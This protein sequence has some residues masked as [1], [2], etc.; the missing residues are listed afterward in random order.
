VVHGISNHGVNA[1]LLDAARTA[2]GFGA[3]QAAVFEAMEEVGYDVAFVKVMPP[4]CGFASRGFEQP[5]LDRM[6][7]RW[8]HYRR[9]LLPLSLASQREGLVTDNDVLGPGRQRLAYYR[10]IVQ[11]QRGTS[12]LLA[13]LSIGNRTVGALLLGRTGGLFKAADLSRVRQWLTPLS[14]GAAAMAWHASP[15]QDRR[16]AEVSPREGEVLRLV[17]LGYT[18]PEIAR[19]LGT[20]PN[21]VRNQVSSLLQKLDASTRAELVGL[22][23]RPP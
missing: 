9:E 16:I 5:L 1:I 20:S 14:L 13:H 11:A 19:A 23:L 8:P 17:Q 12:S 7:A 10:D 22:T 2:P 4:V 21:T 6:R 18:N 3:W 15:A